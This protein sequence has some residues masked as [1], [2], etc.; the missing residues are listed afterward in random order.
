MALIVS[1]FDGSFSAAIIF[2]VHPW[3][4]VSAV[5][6]K[7]SARIALYYRGTYHISIILWY[8]RLHLRPVVPPTSEPWLY[9]TYQIKV[10]VKLNSAAI[11]V[12]TLVFLS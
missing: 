12:Q 9:T 2:H 5:L 3:V 6:A 10:L 1:V 8:V 4:G 7:Q 11:V